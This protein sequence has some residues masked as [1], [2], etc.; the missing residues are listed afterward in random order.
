[1]WNDVLLATSTAR[2]P[3]QASRLSRI[4]RRTL[5]SSFRQS[6]FPPKSA[7]GPP[8]PQLVKAEDGQETVNDAEEE[9]ATPGADEL[10]QAV[11]VSLRAAT[12]RRSSR[13]PVRS[14]PQR[15]DDAAVGQ[16]GRAGGDRDDGKKSRGRATQRKTMPSSSLRPFPV[17]TLPSFPTT[18]PSPSLLSVLLTRPSSQGGWA[19]PVLGRSLAWRASGQS[20]QGAVPGRY[21]PFLAPISARMFV[22]HTTLVRVPA[23]S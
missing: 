8:T 10:E 7:L 22:C 5:R 19:R 16:T 1:M 11:Y 17:S 21:W 6:Y 4:S 15:K 18:T 2:T 9:D 12:L 13:P 20:T 14:A 23:A 3:L